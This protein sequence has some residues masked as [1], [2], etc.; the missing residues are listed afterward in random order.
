MTARTTATINVVDLFAGCGGFTQGFH[1]YRPAPGE[2]SPYRSLAAVEF[3]KAAAATYAVNFG[4]HA[5][6]SC[7]VFAG[8][9]KEWDPSPHKGKVDVILGGPPCQGFSGLGEENPLDPRNKLWREYVRVVAALEP[10][11]FVIENVDRFFNSPEYRALLASNKRGL[12][13]RYNLTARTVLNAADF[14]VPQARKR[15]IVIAT[16]KDLPPLGNPVPTHTKNPS[17]YPTLFDAP[18]PQPWVTVEAIFRKSPEFPL[19]NSLPARQKEILGN[20]VPGIYRTNEL[21]IGR[22]PTPLSLARYKEIPPGGNRKNLRGKTAVIDGE[23]VSLSTD[24]WDRHN[25]GT[26]DVMGRLRLKAPSVTIRTEFFKPE[27]GRYLH[28]LLDRPITHYEAALIQGFPE[29]FKWCGTK[30]QIARQIGNAVPV[31]LAEQ[32]ARHI[33]R[34]LVETKAL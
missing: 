33:H 21:H 13:R 10:K 15:A 12:L 24:S 28:P 2:A 29:E 4:D 16:H 23:I 1:T 34:H 25:S 20:V 18:E 9:I 7:A 30:L 22:N 31:G 3:D 27:K 5:D 6:G 17:E 32:L 19:T 8:D 14:G 26:G 11:I